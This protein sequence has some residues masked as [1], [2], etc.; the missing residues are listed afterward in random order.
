MSR[1]WCEH[2]G[3]GIANDC[4]GGRLN[5]VRYDTPTFAGFS[6]SASWG[7]DDYWDIAAR[8]SGEFSGIKISLATAYSESTDS[9]TSSASFGCNRHSSTAST[10][11]LAV[12]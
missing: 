5:G 1:F 9:Q 3:V 8:Y 7:E 6:L 12:W 4:A 10:S 2:A 11:R